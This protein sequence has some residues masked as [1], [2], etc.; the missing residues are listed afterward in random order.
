MAVAGLARAYLRIDGVWRDHLL[1]ALLE[2]EAPRDRSREA[3]PLDR[4]CL[5]RRH[6]M[7]IRARDHE[8]AT[9]TQ[10]LLEQAR[11]CDRIVAAQR[12]RAHELAEGV[13]R[14]RRR[15]RDRLLLDQPDFDAAL[16]ELPG[17]LASR[18]ASPDDRNFLHTAIF[19]PHARAKRESGLKTRRL[20]RRPSATVLRGARPARA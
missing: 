20:T 19:S 9:A 14:L 1:Y 5:P 18:E 2:R 6:A 3:E 7:L 11:R 4:E 8:R 17:R 13:G 15:S 10:L 12:V 16:G